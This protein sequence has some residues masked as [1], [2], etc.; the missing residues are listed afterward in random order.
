MSYRLLLFI[1]LLL[2]VN[3]WTSVIHTRYY[4]K[5]FNTMVDKYMTGFLGVGMTRSLFKNRSIILLMTN[6]YGI[7]KECQIMSGLTIFTK[8]RRYNLIEGQN[9]NNL[10]Q[11]IRSGKY[12][13]SL[14]QAIDQIN[15]EMNKNE[16]VLGK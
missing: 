13:E 3:I 11:K 14:Q 10:P 7:I 5:T 8:F 15:Y 4:R 6:N 9:I 16:K 2:L 1:L 12:K